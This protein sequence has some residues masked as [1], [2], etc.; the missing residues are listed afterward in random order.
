MTHWR[1]LLVLY[2]R[3]TVWD[4]KHCVCVCALATNKSCCLHF[5]ANNINY[6][7][8]EQV[9]IKTMNDRAHHEEPGDVVGRTA[10]YVHVK[11]L[12]LHVL[13]KVIGKLSNKVKRIWSESSESSN[14][15]SNSSKVTKY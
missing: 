3:A 7:L 11:L 12:L 9:W 10:K 1:Q 13:Y 14:K 4:M 6:T 5:L 15:D 2:K 8:G